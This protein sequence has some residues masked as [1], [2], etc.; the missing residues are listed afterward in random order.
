MPKEL[1]NADRAADIREDRK[2]TNEP[3]KRPGQS[4]QDLSLSPPKK[5]D[6]TSEEAEKNNETA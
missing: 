1:D 4:S 2:G 5:R 3:W 6:L